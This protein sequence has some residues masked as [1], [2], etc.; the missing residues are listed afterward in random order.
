M[1]STSLAG[2]RGLAKAWETND[3]DE[4]VALIKRQIDRSLDDYETV[5]LARKIASGKADGR[6]DGKRYVEAWGEAFVLPDGPPCPMRDGE[7]EMTALWNFWVAN[8]RYV[9]DPPD[10]DLFCTA[11]LTLLA[12]SG[13]CDDGTVGLVALHRAIGFEKCVARI[14]TVG[15]EQWEHIYPLIG[16]PKEGRG[17]V[18]YV[19]LD[20]TVP[21]AKPGY[22][23]TGVAQYR[24]FYV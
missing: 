20:F 6:M 2:S 4:H 8:V 7:C 3:L 22:E 23:F 1:R 14:V 18:E 21:G 9:Y 11:K 15:G 12:G 5:Q 16:L 24:D 19:P 13:D 17:R 10:Y